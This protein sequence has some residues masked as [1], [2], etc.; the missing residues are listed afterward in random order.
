MS[1]VS[2]LTA[3]AATS[4]VPRRSSC[5]TLG[6]SGNRELGVNFL[7]RLPGPAAVVNL[8]IIPPVGGSGAGTGVVVGVVAPEPGTGVV[9]GVVAPVV[10]LS[11]I[12]PVGGSGAGTGVV[13]VV[14]GEVA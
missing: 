14:A 2:S 3:G 11:I 8:C 10:N 13:L 7:M 6:T 4:A 5:F 12:P 1:G 9:V